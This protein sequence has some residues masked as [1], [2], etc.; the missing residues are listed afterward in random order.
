MTLRIAIVGDFREGYEPHQVT[1]DFLAHAA[2]SSNFKVESSWL[3]TDQVTTQTLQPAP[4]TAPISS[5]IMTAAS[6]ST[7][8][9]ATA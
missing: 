2:A 5:N 4:T 9:T 3:P 8:N 7:Q 1:N 6:A